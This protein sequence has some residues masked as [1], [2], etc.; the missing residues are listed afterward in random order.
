MQAGYRVEGA[1]CRVQGLGFES[2]RGGGQEASEHVDGGGLPGAVG[3][4]QREELPLAH[5]VPDVGLI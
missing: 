1:E 3:A 5:I 2:T 4:Q